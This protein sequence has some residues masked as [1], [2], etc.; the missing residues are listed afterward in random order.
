M[1]KILKD[2]PL[3][4]HLARKTFASTIALGNGMA[5]GVVSKIL[6]HASVQ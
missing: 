4:S 1:A 5:I 3:V 6:G 2:K